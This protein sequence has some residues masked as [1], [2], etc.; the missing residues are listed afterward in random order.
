V[1]LWEALAGRRLYQGKND[2]DLF[3]SARKA[4]IPSLGELRD[5]LPPDLVEALDRALSREPY[6]RFASARQML[7]A[8]T[9]QLKLVRDPVDSPVLAHSVREA[10]QLLQHA[11][12]RRPRPT[13][14]VTPDET[15]SPLQSPTTALAGPGKPPPP[16]RRRRRTTD[17]ATNSTGIEKR[18]SR[19]QRV[20][21]IARRKSAPKI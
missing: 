3:V 9:D 11:A 10:L 17:N 19:L 4:E 16:P 7:R 13:G 15:D 1:V 5:D 18:P 12:Q 8:L 21:S 14:P 20:L 2:V 6:H